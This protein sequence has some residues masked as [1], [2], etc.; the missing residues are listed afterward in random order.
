[1]IIDKSNGTI[2]VNS[3]FRLD[4][5]LTLSNFVASPDFR[6][7]TLVGQSGTIYRRD[8]EDYEKRILTIW[9]TFFREK[10]QYILVSF[11]LPHE[12]NRRICE[13]SSQWKGI[14]I[15]RERLHEQ[16]LVDDLGSPPY[17]YAWGSIM[18]GGSNIDPCSAISV[19]YNLNIK[20]DPT[21]MVK[22]F[23]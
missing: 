5:K 14:D 4:T 13:R 1:M 19:N 2:T 16:I 7:W 6:N 22:G 23:G 15:N 3:E 9:T 12:K 21:L 11:F 10:L 20:H 18:I 17:E 8:S